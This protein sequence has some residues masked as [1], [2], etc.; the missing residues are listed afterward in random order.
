MSDPS[1]PDFRRSEAGKRQSW[2]GVKRYVKAA[3]SLRVP[4]WVLRRFL[5]LRPDLRRSGR[6][7][8]PRHVTE[9]EG[10]AGTASFAML[11]PDRCV[12]AK[13]LY[14]GRGRRPRAEDALAIEVFAAL[15]NEADVVLDVGA[16]T[17]IFSLVATAVNPA[18]QVHA[19]EIVPAVVHLL[20]E[21]CRRNGVQDRVTI[22]HE[23]LGTPGGT[24]TVPEGSGGSAL[25]DFYSTRL[26]F[27]AGS[28]VDLVALDAY[29][30]IAPPGSRVLMKIDV[31]GSEDEVLAH[32]ARVLAS[33]GPD[34]L[35][36]ILDGVADASA[37][38][39]SLAPH[40]Y[41]YYMV[42]DHDLQERPAIVP[43]PRFRDWLFS[44]RGPADL[45]ALT[46]V[47]MLPT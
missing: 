14:W 31:E 27:E 34:I 10:R 38:E 1:A 7:P 35:C 39:R 26:H 44:R 45:S 29:A 20:R 33:F 6:L 24:I 13:E 11:R 42:R 8:A 16:Y 25:P 47:R 5:V 41:R 30:D 32:G 37:V 21:N 3:L 9:V 2:H 28:K 17:G 15:S 40:A 12:V 22:H 36:E 23:A 46:G 4:H 18:V 19:F 43:D